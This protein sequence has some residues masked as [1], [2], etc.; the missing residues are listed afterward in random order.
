LLPKLGPQ[1]VV[2]TGEAVTSRRGAFKRKSNYQ[3]RNPSAV[4]VFLSFNKAVII[5]KCP[6]VAGTTNKGHS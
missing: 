1:L 4:L 5:K 2:I 6:K 3:N